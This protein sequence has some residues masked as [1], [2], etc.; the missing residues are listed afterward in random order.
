M[1]RAVVVGAS[2]AGLLAARAVSDHADKVTIIE[3]DDLPDGPDARKGVP[4]GRHAHALLASGGEVLEQFFPGLLGELVSRGAVPMSV[5]NGR[6]WQRGGYRL[7]P[8]GIDPPIMMSRPFLEH[9]VR[10]R[11]RAVPNVTFLRGAVTDISVGGVGADGVVATIADREERVG[12]DLVVDASGRGSQAA[13]WLERHGYQP[14]QAAEIRI[15]M[16]YASRFF[17]R[18]GKRP[19][20]LWFGSVGDATNGGRTAGMFEVE[21]DRYLVSLGGFHGD[22]PPTDDAGFRSFAEALPSEDVGQLIASEE[23]LGPI[24]AHRVPSNLWRHFEKIKA[25]PAGFVAI[26]DAIASFNPV[27]GQGMSVAALE[28]KALAGCVGSHGL[29]SERLPAAF[30]R[31][32]A[33]VIN[34][35]WT[36]AA[37]ADFQ[38]PQTTGPKPPF[39]DLFNGYSERLLRAAQTDMAVAR[40]FFDVGNLTASPT[41]LMSPAMLVRV[42]RSGGKRAGDRVGSG[43]ASAN[44]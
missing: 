9:A 16:A 35:P 17:R 2:I 40:A 11:V 32:T 31:Q 19:G 5:A 26:G 3:R 10:E 1:G 8:P 44:T 18:S 28:A 27:Y 23:P 6:I 34:N 13:R 42:L 21:G 37:G 7:V 12:A 29:S 22:H 43:T 33:K 15:D 24:V 39:M 30:Y 20:G 25:S 14:P 38:L 36:I 4:Q 41:S